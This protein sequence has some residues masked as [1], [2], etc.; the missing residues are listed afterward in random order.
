MIVVAVAAVVLV[1]PT[2]TV[3]FIVGLNVAEGLVFV[4]V[5]IPEE[6]FK[7]QYIFCPTDEARPPDRE[8]NELCTER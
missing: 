3:Q 2:A 4:E 7:S 8:A 1:A 5:G 6:R